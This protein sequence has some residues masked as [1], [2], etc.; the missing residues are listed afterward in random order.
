M[1]RDDIRA[2]QTIALEAAHR[3]KDHDTLERAQRAAVE[4]STHPDLVR[5]RPHT[6][7]QGSAGLALLFGYLDDCFPGQGWEIE[8]RWHLEAAARAVQAS[9]EIGMSLYGGL[10]GVA[11]AAYSRSHGGR[12]YRRLS[13]T[14][15]EAL[16]PAIEAS[17]AA[18]DAMSGGCAVHHFDVIGGVTGAG[19]YLLCRAEHEGARTGLDR[20]LRCLVSLTNDDDEGLPR[21]RTPAHLILPPEQARNFPGGHL[22]FG[23][24][25]GIPGPLVVLSLAGRH[26]IS[27]PGME[28]AVERI[29]ACLLTHRADDDRGVNWTTCHPL[30][31]PGEQQGT[32]AKTPPSRTAWCYGIPGISR[33]LYLAGRAFAKPAWCQVAVDAMRSAVTRP[34]PERHI[35]SPTFCHGVA[36]LL[37]ITSRFA[38]DTGLAVFEEAKG[39][40][41]AQLVA[42]HEPASI[43]GFRSIDSAGGRVDDPG[44]LDGTPG[45]ILSLLAATMPVEPAWDRLFL[46]S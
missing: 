26:G 42:A 39:A 44:L 7:H 16:S 12:R 1:S 25:H 2:A 3:L 33:A 22:N 8:A 20:V 46:L 11:F 23:L 43:L 9:P 15:D 35:P 5:W 37:H 18:L 32:L 4:Q 10:A 29:V 40:L 34:V 19:A 14:L 30:P 17:C 27:V 21:W 28:E 24:A 6:L 31:L 13:A 41:I 45:V 38:R 36:G